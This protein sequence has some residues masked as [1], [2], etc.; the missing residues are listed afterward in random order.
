MVALGRRERTLIGL[1]L[2]LVLAVGGYLQLI[3][4]WRARQ[5]ETAEIIPTREATLEKRRLLVG[6]RERLQAD[7]D[8]VSQKVTE[9]SA[10]LL[11]GPTAPLAASELQRLIKEMA[12]GAAVDIRSERVLTPL[13]LSGVLEI[14]IE[15]TVAGN[16][17]QIVALLARLE[18]APH[19]LTVKD[20]AVRVAAPGQSRE[21]LTTLV[22]AGYL[23][24]GH[25]AARPEPAG[26]REST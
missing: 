11:P 9:A 2:V 3:E 15:L 21:L 19:L 16:I 24:P 23:R 12:T 14:P 17:R 18:R 6:Q 22:V 7:L 5:R 20:I 1:G 13:D 26:M 8:V 10:S 25:G 4:P